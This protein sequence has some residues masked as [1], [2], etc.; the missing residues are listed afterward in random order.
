MPDDDYLIKTS[1]TRYVSAEE[2]KT[3]W[4]NGRFVCKRSH[5][6]CGF[7]HFTAAQTSAPKRVFVL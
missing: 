6:Q 1:E 3:L 4:M 2:W 7:K 5:I